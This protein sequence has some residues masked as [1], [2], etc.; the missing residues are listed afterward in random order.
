LAPIPIIVKRPSSLDVDIQENRVDAV[1]VKSSF[2]VVIVVVKAVD[3]MSIGESFLPSD[4]TTARKQQEN[5]N[6]SNKG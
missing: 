4:S 2:F 3:L 1:G 6:G 5:S